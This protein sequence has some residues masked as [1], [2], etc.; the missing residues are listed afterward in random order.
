M[1]V[2]RVEKSGK[3]IKFIFEDYS[4]NAEK[5]DGVKKKD[6]VG[7]ELLSV[8]PGAKEMGI[9]DALERVYRTGK[10]EMLEMRQYKDQELQFWRDNYIFKDDQGMVVAIYRDISEHITLELDLREKVAQ[11]EKI[12]NLMVG[13]ELK[14]I[15]LKKEIERL[16]S[17]SKK[18]DD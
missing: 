17:R 13:R 16:K 4:K 10:A 9:V 2:Y 8:F 1:A 14:M 7:K 6:L 18:D 5:L 11:L 12:N 3:K 15:E